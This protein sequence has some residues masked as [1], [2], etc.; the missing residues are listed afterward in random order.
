MSDWELAQLNIAEPAAALDS[1]ELADFVANLDRINQLADESP[2][3]VWRLID[4][5]GDTPGF[6][7]PF[8]EHMI[9]NMSV[10]ESVDALHHYVYRTA[11]TSVMRR[12]KEWFVSRDHASAVLWWVPKGHRPDLYEAEQKLL[13]LEQEGSTTAAFTFKARQDKPSS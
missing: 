12:R 1:P 3:F 7:D 11:H 8:G 6:S 13:L 9:V 2:G 5:Q 10:W 4:E